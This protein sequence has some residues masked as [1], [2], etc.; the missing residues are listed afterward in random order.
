[1]A[2]SRR[3]VTVE[4]MARVTV[5]SVSVVWVPERETVAVAAVEGELRDFV[6]REVEVG[7]GGGGGAPRESEMEAEAPS[8]TEADAARDEEGAMMVAVS[9]VRVVLDFDTVLTVTG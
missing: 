2:V 3:V 5:G 8:D 1:M 7:L 6:E 4:G 9:V